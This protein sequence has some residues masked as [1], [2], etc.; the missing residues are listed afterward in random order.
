VKEINIKG[1]AEGSEEVVRE[2]AQTRVRTQ[3]TAAEASARQSGQRGLNEQSW[4]A[5]G[6]QQNSLD[7]GMGTGGLAAA[8]SHQQCTGGAGE[9]L[10]MAA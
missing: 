3:P 6:R 1:P 5:H 8:S 4:Q 10:V 7:H 2:K 9:N